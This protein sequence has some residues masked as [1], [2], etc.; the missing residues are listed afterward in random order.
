MEKTMCFKRLNRTVFIAS[1]LLL[2]TTAYTHSV[3]AA[4]VVVNP[5]LPGVGVYVGGGS[6]YNG[7]GYRHGYYGNAYHH[8]AYGNTAYHHGYG[9]GTAVHHGAY[10][11]TAYHHGNG[12]GTVV[13]NG[14]VHHYRR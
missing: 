12:H 5:P 7:Y 11:N 2:L 10:G 1:L 14:N 6:G 3:H 9:H 8:G 13:H 4:V